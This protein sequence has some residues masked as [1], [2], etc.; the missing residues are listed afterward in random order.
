M[1]MSKNQTQ[2]NKDNIRK[3]N[4]G[5]DHD[6][7]V[8]DKVGITN[9]ASFKYETPYNGPFEIKRCC[10]NV[11]V[12]LKCSEIKIRYNVCFIQIY[13]SDTNVEDIKCWE[14]I[15]N[16]VKLGKYTLR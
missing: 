13:T 1:N 2:I 11:T 6:Y 7:K 12:T 8:G 16:D 5:V 14:L 10:N 3:N 4:T 15:I 9:N